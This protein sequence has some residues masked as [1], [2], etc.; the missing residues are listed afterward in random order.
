MRAL[1][2][3]GIFPWAFGSIGAGFVLALR[4]LL[5][6]LGQRISYGSRFF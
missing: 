5:L 2:E 3:F 6:N 1:P 4:D